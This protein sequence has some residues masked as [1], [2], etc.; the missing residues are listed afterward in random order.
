MYK[1]LLKPILDW[2]LSLTALII[3]SPVFALIAIAIKVD[4]KGPVFFTQE[5]LGRNGR[6]FRI[7]KFRS[8]NQ[9][10]VVPVG[11]RKVFESDTRITTVGRFIRKTSLDELPQLF[12]ILKGEMSFIGPRPPVTTFPKH[13]DEYTELERVRFLVKPGISG[14]V[15]VRQREI[16]DWDLNIPVDIEYVNNYSFLYDVRLFTRSLL[17]FFRTDNIYTRE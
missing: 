16:N 12:N 4:S 1:F 3:L 10:N 7:Y 13:Y 2:I 11:S 17:I 8:M 5:R 15:Q 14:L 6:I 9:T